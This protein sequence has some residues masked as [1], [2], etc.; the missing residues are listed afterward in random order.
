MF[1]RESISPATV[2]VTPSSLHLVAGAINECVV[3]VT[4]VSEDTLMFRTLTTTPER[5]LVKP[6]KG[7]IKKNTTVSVLIMLNMAA[8]D[9]ETGLQANSDDFRIE[10]CVLTPNDVIEQRCANVPA[11]I[12][13]RKQED[14]RLVHSRTLRCVLDW[15]SAGSTAVDFRDGDKD[16]IKFVSQAQK[17]EVMSLSDR[18]SNSSTVM[19]NIAVQQGGGA[20]SAR[21]DVHELERN[22]LN[23]KNMRE[24][25]QQ[26]QA[27]RRKQILFA[28]F[29]VTVMLL[30]AW[31]VSYGW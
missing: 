16:K 26:K 21:T 30:C 22:S 25:V 6:T 23:S 29:V 31:T 9:G 14:R 12:K 1:N 13:A 15:Q 7:I 10:Y 20:A 2:V 4:N 5:Y 18:Q 3:K 11:I 28:A 17:D 19:D 27:V 8:I 24:F